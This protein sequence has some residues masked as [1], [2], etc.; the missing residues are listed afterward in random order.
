MVSKNIERLSYASR[1]QARKLI[2]VVPADANSSGY[3]VPSSDYLLKLFNA[4]YGVLSVHEET[5]ILGKLAYSQEMLALLEYLKMRQI[6][7]VLASHDV[8]KDF[9]DLYPPGF[10]DIAGLLYVPLSGGGRDFIA[11]FRRGQLTEIEWAWNPYK[12]E[13]RGGTSDYLGPKKPFQPWKE[14]VLTGR[15]REWTECDLEAAAVLCVVYGKFIEVWRQNEAAMQ[16]SQLTKLL[17]ANSAH[18]VRTPL[19]AIINYLEIALEGALDLETR[20]NLAKS[21]SASK[22]LIYVINDLL[23]LTN[24]ERGQSLIKDEVFNLPETLKEATDMFENEV[25]R[26]GIAYNITLHPGIPISVKGDQHRVRQVIMNVISNAVQHTLSG[27]IHV[28]FRLP[29]GQPYSGYVDVEVAVH[30]TGSG[31][32]QTTI[33]ILFRD[34]EQVAAEDDRH[35]HEQISTCGA[36]TFV[37]GEEKRVL[38]LGL[39]FVARF[40]Q[41]MHGQLSVKSEEGKGSHFKLLLRFPLPADHEHGTSTGGSNLPG[42]SEGEMPLT[43]S[44]NT[45]RRSHDKSCDRAS[46]ESMES[47]NSEAD[48]Y[49]KQILPPSLP[50]N[51][52][53]TSTNLEQGSAESEGKRSLAPD[54]KHPTND[55]LVAGSKLQ[56]E[57]P[58]HIAIPCSQLRCIVPLSPLTPSGRES[59]TE[60]KGPLGAVHVPFCHVERSPPF[61]DLYRYWSG[62]AALP[63]TTSES[64]PEMDIPSPNWIPSASVVNSLHVLVAEDDPVNSKVLQKRLKGSGHSVHLT[65]NGEDCA[66][67]YRADPN[68]FDV[69]LMD[70]QVS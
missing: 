21:H 67:A 63:S 55:S 65:V 69:I 9:P 48:Q 59:A 6:N 18:E 27:S 41:N 37:D 42:S 49:R 29:P 64:S 31:M 68:S 2:N 33:D 25:E 7:L 54:A 23:D 3:L 70:I 56:T 22:S 45:C 46:L 43:V 32:S 4:D 51:E 39:A 60:S 53:P 62:S 36:T 44:N 66:A 38:G 28:E 14:T 1:L 19:N 57:R 35:Y 24:T 30:D 47:T 12:P 17:L 58:S 50:V 16:R 40:V 52:A 10:K 20:E 26:K 13:P 15:S 8:S 5:K 34:L 61:D 11:F